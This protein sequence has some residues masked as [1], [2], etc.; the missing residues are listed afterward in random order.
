MEW[1]I[2]LF[3]VTLPCV[4]PLLIV[5]T[6]RVG[7]TNSSLCEFHRLE[8]KSLTEPASHSAVF[9]E[10]R[11][12]LVALQKVMGGCLIVLI[13]FLDCWPVFRMEPNPQRIFLNSS[14]L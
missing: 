13:A 7:W 1:R 2:C 4:V 6:E 14:P 5:G 12:L 9:H 11:G 3:G 8:F 10:V